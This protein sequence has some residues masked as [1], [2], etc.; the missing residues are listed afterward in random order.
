[1]SNRDYEETAQ[2]LLAEAAAGLDRVM[3]NGVVLDDAALNT[4]TDIRRFLCATPS[5]YTGRAGTCPECHAPIKVRA[6][7]GA[8][9]GLVILVGSCGHR[10]DPVAFLSAES[11]EPPA[12]APAERRHLEEV[13][14]GLPG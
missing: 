12:P 4:R 6:W 3:D 2:R 1:M 7:E 5:R 10:F 9:G 13:E 8:D 11:L 14:D